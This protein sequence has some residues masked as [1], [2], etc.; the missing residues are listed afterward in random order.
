MKTIKGLM[1]KD[2]YVFKNYRGNIIFSF[3][4]FVFLITLAAFRMDVVAGGGIVFLIFFGMNSISSF[5]YDENALADKYLLSLPISRKDIVWGKYLFTFLNSLLSILVG[6]GISLIITWLVR[7]NVTNLGDALRLCFIAFTS[8][9]FLMCADIPCIYKWGV[10]KG[11]M[12]SVLV[13]VLL[14][15]VL[16]ILGSLILLLFPA[17]YNLLDLEALF[18]VSPIICLMLN[19]L[20]YYI[21]FQISYHIFKNK[22]L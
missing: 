19:I 18:Y 8:V 21:S 2:L 12:Q 7:G 5:S 13:P 1:L 17:L 16:G 4:M 15:F 10:E 14:I 22:E 9:S 11:R 6:V 3:I 20:F